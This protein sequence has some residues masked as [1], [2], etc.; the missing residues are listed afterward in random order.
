VGGGNGRKYRLVVSSK[1]ITSRIITRHSD[2]N[3]SHCHQTT[4]LGGGKK[5][6]VVSS[7]EIT[8]RICHAISNLNF[9]NAMEHFFLDVGWGSRC[10]LLMCCLLATKQQRDHPQ[11]MGWLQ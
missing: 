3:Q 6:F 5:N 2:Q 9:P 7:K 8:P 10:H 11:H 1:E 4:F